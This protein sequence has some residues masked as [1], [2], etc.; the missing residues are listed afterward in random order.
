MTGKLNR[1]H[2]AFP[3]WDLNERQRPFALSRPRQD[4]HNPRIPY[5][6]YESLEAQ[7]ELK[8][9]GHATHLFFFRQNLHV[10]VMFRSQSMGRQR[11]QDLFPGLMLLGSAYCLICMYFFQL[12]TRISMTFRFKKLP[13][14]VSYCIAYRRPPD[15]VPSGSFH[16]CR[17]F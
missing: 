15:R 17:R 1:P 12:S 3:E 7:R 2:L 5:F 13:S 14:F 8:V 6:Q 9:E 10:R 16:E 4:F 11:R